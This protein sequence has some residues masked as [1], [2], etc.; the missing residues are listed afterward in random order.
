M[1]KFEQIQEQ[2]SMYCK[3]NPTE[4]ISEN[5]KSSEDVKKVTSA[6]ARCCDSSGE[7]TSRS[8]W[9]WKVE[10]RLGPMFSIRKL[11]TNAK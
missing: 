8:M 11:H 1:N 5:I 9:D 2:I 10:A 3:S 6:A 4:D 7:L